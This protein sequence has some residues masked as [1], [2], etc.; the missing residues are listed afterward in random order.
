[1]KLLQVSLGSVR[2]RIYLSD[3]PYSND[4]ALIRLRGTSY[5]NSHIQFICVPG[6]SE[7]V[8]TGEWCIVSGWGA[9]KGK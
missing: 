9:D 5:L 8:T 2:H 3:G 7:E 1:M 4:I 6:Q